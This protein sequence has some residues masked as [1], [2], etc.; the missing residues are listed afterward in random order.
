MS[1]NFKET[2]FTLDDWKKM[3]LMTASLNVFTVDW[4]QEGEKLTLNI[5]QQV[6]Y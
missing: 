5:K 6:N 3:W 1:Y 4:K 2:E